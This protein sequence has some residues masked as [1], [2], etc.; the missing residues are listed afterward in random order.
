MGGSQ[1]HYHRL[2][3]STFTISKKGLKALADTVTSSRRTLTLTNVLA[4]ETN[5]P[6]IDDTT[7]NS[8]TDDTTNPLADD[9]IDDNDGFLFPGADDIF[10]ANYREFQL[11]RLKYKKLYCWYTFAAN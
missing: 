11:H 1:E 8:P 7:N 4:D 3:T 9:T 2:G 10:T 6:P 5:N